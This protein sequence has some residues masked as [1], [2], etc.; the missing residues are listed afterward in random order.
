MVTAA[1]NQAQ[2]PTKCVDLGNYTD[3]LWMKLALM[4][5][6]DSIIK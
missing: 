6:I 5:S 4:L 1:E 3:R 2:G